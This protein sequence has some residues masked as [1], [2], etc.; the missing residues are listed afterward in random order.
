MGS[1]GRASAFR[2]EPV[3]EGLEPQ[4]GV[5]QWIEATQGEADV[6]DGRAELAGV[7]AEVADDADPGPRT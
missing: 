1:G 7:T 6:L 4:E 3:V 2:A 5:D